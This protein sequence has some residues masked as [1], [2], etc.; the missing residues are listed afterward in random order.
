MD[1]DL[2]RLR[3]I[4]CLAGIALTTALASACGGGG[5]A[6]AAAKDP[7]LVKYTGSAL[8]FS[9]PAAWRTHQWPGNFHFQPLVYLSTQPTHNP[10][11]THGNETTCG[12]PVQRLQPGGIVAVWQIPYAPPC[13]GCSSRPTGTP[14]R[15]GGRRATRQVTAGGECRSIGADRTIDVM[16]GNSSVEFTACLRGP[17]L[18]QN[19][20]RVDALLRSTRFP[21][22]SSSSSAS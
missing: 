8:S 14:L 19:E 9:H 6:Q 11:V 13:T 17:N 16:V 15:V 18:A 1:A 3:L 10:C 21:A 12:L 7:P 4:A 5:N 20:R 22:E 2:R